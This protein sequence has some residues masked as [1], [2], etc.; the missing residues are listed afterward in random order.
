MISKADAIVIGSG[1][2]GAA[3]AYYL[4]ERKRLSVVRFYDETGLEF[5]SNDYNSIKPYTQGSYLNAGKVAF[6]PN[7]WINAAMAGIGDG[8]NGGGRSG[9]SLTLT[10]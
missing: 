10:R 9:R 4:S 2:L 6:R 8:H 1:G 5:T 7:N 3:T